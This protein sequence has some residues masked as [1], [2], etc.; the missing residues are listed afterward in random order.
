MV[1]HQVSVGSVE[2]AYLTLFSRSVSLRPTL[3]VHYSVLSVGLFRLG[4]EI[5]IHTGLSLNSKFCF[6]III[7]LFFAIYH[8][9]TWHRYRLNHD[10]LLKI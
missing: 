1:Y 7:F 10:L 3:P 4:N 5:R 9:I 2:T 6:A 8:D